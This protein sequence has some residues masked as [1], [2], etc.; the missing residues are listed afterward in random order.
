[1]IHRF[2][3]A[4][5]L[6]MTGASIGVSQNIS[7]FQKQFQ[8]NITATSSEIKIDGL[9]EEP[10]WKTA[11]KVSIDNKKY[12]NNIGK[13]QQAT[14][15][16]CTFD[17]KNMYFAFIVHSKGDQLIK[18]LKR[19]V[20]YE[21]S[22][23]ISIVLDPLN[24]KT[25]GFFFVL[26]ASNVQSEDQLT[27]SSEDKPSWSWDTRWYS[28]TKIYEDY[29]IAEIAIPFK[30][31]R[32]N[33]LQTVWGINFL[34][35]D[36]KSNEYNCWTRVVPTFH[37]YDLG[38]TGMVTFPSKLPPNNNNI[39]LQPFVTGNAT[40][41]HESA[42]A[43]GGTG[44]AGFDAK[45]TLNSS[46]NMDVTVNPDFSQVEIDQQVT[47]LTR[48]NIFLP[49]KRNFFMENSDL[50]AGFGN[51]LYKPFYSRTIGLDKEGNQIP[52]LIGA[53][54]SGNLSPSVRIG[55]MN[56][57]TGKK[58]DYA[59][60]N[61]TAFTIQK[62]FWARSVIKGY[63][64]NREN[65]ISEEKAAMNPLD[66]FGRN[67]GVSF[68]YTNSDGTKNVEVNYHHSIKPTIQ[69]L[70]GY[71]DASITRTIKNTTY[72]AYA[73]NVGKNYYTDM[74]YVQRIENYDAIRDTVIRQGYKNLFGNISHK[75]FFAKGP[76]G[77]IQLNLEELVNFTPD[78][79]FNENELNFKVSVEMKSSSGVSLTSSNN[80]LNLLFPTQPGDGKPLPIGTYRYTNYNL[81]YFSDMR[82]LFSY[83]VGVFAGEYYN[84]TVHGWGAGVNWRKQPHLNI[85][86]NFQI[87]EISLPHPYGSAKLLL[88]APKIEYNFNTKLFWTSFIQYNTQSNNFNINSRLQYRYRPMSDFYLVYTDNYFTDP[89]FKNKNRALIFKFSYW[90][91]L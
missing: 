55:M 80:N 44:N 88:I 72:T 45:F 49:E 51:P 74:G 64:L 59:P 60:E 35:A 7:D 16:M 39:I 29:W 34:R 85:D 89:L 83:R 65:F 42:N 22:D 38:Y 47:N 21:G 52:I 41:D 31:L 50:F 5:L 62:R 87:N 73:G 84:G 20:G 26:T 8:L 17:D 27:S 24:Q 11:Q 61:F 10:I 4:F 91:N 36:F 37:S 19:D 32:Y 48:F 14:E 82:K 81:M 18:S 63:F 86:I 3:L 56:M 70:N 40:Q 53:R 28:A 30:S 71:V 68:N 23:G 6:I 57:Q 76:I 79:T 25:N 12:P 77:R 1:M 13:P 69:N 67:V 33:E 54:L 66:R 46:L 2:L 15:A 9:L 75:I 58:G 78:N 43:H 90:F